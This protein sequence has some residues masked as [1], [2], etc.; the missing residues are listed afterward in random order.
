MA[1]PKRELNQRVSEEGLSAG[2]ETAVIPTPPVAPRAHGSAVRDSRWAVILA[3]GDGVRLRS[4]T[5][6]ICGDNRP[7][8][9][10]PLFEGGTLLGHTVRRA[11]RSIPAAQI[12]FALTHTHRDFYVQRT[13][14]LPGATNRA[15]CEQ[16]YCSADIV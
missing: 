16:G 1:P 15:A 10:C 6:F 4:L 12:L 7:K 9:F 14:W 5:R 11:V 3:G 8:Q 13:R 2:L